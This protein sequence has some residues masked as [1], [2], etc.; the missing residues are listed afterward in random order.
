MEYGHIFTCAPVPLRI[1]RY[2]YFI[3]SH[4]T[5]GSTRYSFI[6]MRWI[7]WGS[8]NR[9]LSLLLRPVPGSL[10]VNWYS[11]KLLYHCLEY[12]RGVAWW[13]CSGDRP[14]GQPQVSLSPSDS[15]VLLAHIHAQMLRDHTCM[16]LNGQALMHPHT[17]IRMWGSSVTKTRSSVLCSRVYTC[18]FC[19]HD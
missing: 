7:L 17:I 13:G 18:I 10:D 2:F 3:H 19:Q 5:P 12:W 8:D 9:A 4:V 11:P 16:H 15:C 14:S 1:N 6:V